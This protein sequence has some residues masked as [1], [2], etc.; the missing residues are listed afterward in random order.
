MHSV[1]NY[2][3]LYIKLLQ[4]L[5]GLQTTITYFA[6]EFSMWADLMEAVLCL[7]HNV[8]GINSND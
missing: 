7:L 5:S 1:S 3:Q 8:W 6:P 2:L 4:I